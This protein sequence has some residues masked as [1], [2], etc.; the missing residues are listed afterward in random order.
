MESSAGPLA[1]ILSAIK[2]RQL[3]RWQELPDLE[4]YMDQVLSLTERYLGMD[5]EHAGRGLTASMVNNYVKLGVMPS[6]VK[7][8]Y[9]RKHLAYLIMICALK[10]ILPM[11]EIRALLER[12][13]ADTPIEEVYDRFRA[14]YEQ[15]GREAADACRQ[16]GG[17]EESEIVF[18][19][20]L[21]ARAEQTIARALADASREAGRDK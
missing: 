12:T 13:T 11:A 15:T 16:A 7:K 2:T 9:T 6:P 20:A 19:T 4:L 5:T 21:R 14:L 18:R 10:E 17:E 1:G 8:R 3:P